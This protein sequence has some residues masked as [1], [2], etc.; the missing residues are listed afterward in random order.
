MIFSDLFKNT[1]I[2]FSSKIDNIQTNPSKTKTG[3]LVILRF[4]A[5]Q[6]SINL[7]LE[8]GAIAVIAPKNTNLKKTKNLLMHEDPALLYSSLVSKIYTKQPENVVCVTGTNG[9]TS[10][11]EFCRQIWSNMGKKSASLGTLGLRYENHIY[12][13]NDCL[14]TPDAKDLHRLLE[15]S[16]NDDIDCLSM[17]ASSHGI[18][19]KRLDN[20]KFKAAAFTNFSHDHLDYHGNLRRYFLAKQRLF[21]QVLSKNSTAILNQDIPEYRE[22]NIFQSEIITY[23]KDIFRNANVKLLKQQPSLLGQNLTISSFGHKYKIE[24]PIIGKFQAEN[25]LCALGL[26]KAC[27]D[28]PKEKDLYIN[29]PMGRMELVNK[30]ETN[31]VI[32]YSHTPDALKNA[33]LSLKWHGF[34]KIIIV[35]GCG[36]NR[37][38]KKRYEMGKIAYEYADEVIISDDNPRG[39]DAST[40]RKQILTA[41]KQAIE[42]PNRRRAIIEGLNRLKKGNVLLVAGKGH[43]DKLF[44]KNDI[45]IE[46]N[47]KK[48]ILDCL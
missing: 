33:L 24:L 43:E 48:I 10:V 35:F 15:Q 32:D 12:H 17:E 3:D 6:E 26:I 36:G 13:H 28:I 16:K 34:N 30:H 4:H 18:H 8:K 2:S 41:A 22:L 45:Y 1:E 27:G 29:A 42:I 11:V 47:D 37:D 46:S 44:I 25:I 7:A 21:K 38:K 5:S 19:Q 9:K 14:S 40:I 23:T 39:E 20:V 31:V